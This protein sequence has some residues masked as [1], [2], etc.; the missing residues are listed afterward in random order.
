M[1]I[2]KTMKE[3]A[4]N[5]TK[6]QKKFVQNHKFLPPFETYYYRDVVWRVGFSNS[7]LVRSPVDYEHKIKIL[8]GKG[9]NSR[10]MKSIVNRRPWLQITDKLED[11]SIVW[12][13]L[14]VASMYTTQN[15]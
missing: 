1:K 15:C 8:I 10:L 3:I 2:T 13:Q 5:Y 7:H 6:Y 12:T 9:N 4:P 11:A 14:K